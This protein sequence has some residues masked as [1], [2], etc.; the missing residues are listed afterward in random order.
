MPGFFGT[1][2]GEGFTD[3]V[4][5]G[6]AAG[7]IASEFIIGLAASIL[8]VEVDFE[9]SA[10]GLAPVGVVAGV[11]VGVGFGGLYCSAIVGFESIKVGNFIRPFF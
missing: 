5:D 1:G 8:G 4:G 10:V 3:G 6:A 11:G 9:A 2:V 7:I